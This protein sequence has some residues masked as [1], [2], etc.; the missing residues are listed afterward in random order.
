MILHVL[1]PEP[2]GSAPAGVFPLSVHASGRYHSQADGTPWFMQGDTAWSI[3][4]QLNNTQIIAYLD[5]R[6]SR[7]F[8]AI[9]CNLIEHEFTDNT[10]A[11]EDVLGN[12]PF[13]TTDAIDFD[14]P[15]DTYFNRARDYLVSPAY[16]RDIL[17]IMAPA[18][19]G[20][21]GGSQGF[22]PQIQN[23][24]T[25]TMQAWGEYLGT[26]FAAYPNIMWNMGGDW[27]DAAALTRINAVQT[28]LAATG[29]ANWKYT[30]HSNPEDSARDSI[31]D[32]GGQSWI[33][34]DWVYSYNDVVNVLQASYARA[35]AKPMALF[36]TRYEG[37]GSPTADAIEIR[38]NMWWSVLAGGYGHV[39]GNNPIWGFDLAAP[40]F[41][42]T[43]TWTDYLDSQGSLDMV[44][45]GNFF[46]ALD[47]HLLVPD[48]A[49]TVMTAGHESGT[50]EA[51]CEIAS[52]DSF[53]VVYMP[54]ER[55]VTI[56][57]TEFAGPNVLC[58]WFSPTTAGYTTIGTYAN[59]G[60]RN[61][62]P[63][64]G[65]WVLLMESTA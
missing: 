27:Y 62:T 33:T 55:Q 50:T 64:S 19:L 46:R 37:E 31:E 7:G 54:T 39:F 8:N 26:K 43:G 65:D 41:S 9:I 5:D 63:S 29:N 15:S 13:T 48:T 3:L 20:Y 4:Q 6:Q 22:W 12:Q 21:Q 44:R 16:D 25:A 56:D 17:L 24:S 1:T 53:A 34:D 36:E 57:M 10:P 61:F 32:A 38:R 47:W 40:I 18:Y 49:N 14:A 35:T 23:E 58:R 45:M 60:T 11:W 59:T 42:Y 52:D 51:L 2:P 30:Y 28:G